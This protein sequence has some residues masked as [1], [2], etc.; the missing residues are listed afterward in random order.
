MKSTSSKA[1]KTLSMLAGLSAGVLGSGMNAL[2]GAIKPHSERNSR[3]RFW[4]NGQLLYSS[5]G[6][7]WQQIHDSNNIIRKGKAK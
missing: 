4:F 5:D 3:R 2:A 7:T 6:L 1:K